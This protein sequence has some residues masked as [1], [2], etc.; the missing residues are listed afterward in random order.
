MYIIIYIYILEIT[1]TLIKESLRRSLKII[2]WNELLAVY[3][4]VR[5]IFLEIFLK[6]IL[7]RH[8]GHAPLIRA[9]KTM[10]K[11]ITKNAG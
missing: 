1:K 10:K 5:S 4:N 9:T 2:D 8:E 3:C 7:D 11:K 6:P